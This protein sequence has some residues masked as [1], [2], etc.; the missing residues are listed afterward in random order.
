[1]TRHCLRTSSQGHT[2]C[3]IP[4]LPNPHPLLSSEGDLRVGGHMT[5]LLST[6]CPLNGRAT[7]DLLVTRVSH[8][9]VISQ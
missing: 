3:G 7:D 9:S 2:G 8:L 4:V 5:S 1:M 6:T